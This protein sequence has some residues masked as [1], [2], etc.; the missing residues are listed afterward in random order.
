MASE[1]MTW[2]PYWQS[3]NYLVLYLIV[4]QQL[5]T[6]INQRIDNQRLRLQL[7][8]ETQKVGLS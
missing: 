2:E 4:A 8:K 3:V 1:I 5:H 7:G 6:G